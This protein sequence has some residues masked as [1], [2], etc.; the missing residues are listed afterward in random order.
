[1]PID[2]FKQQDTYLCIAFNSSDSIMVTGNETDIKI[3]N[4]NNRRIQL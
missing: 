3:W 2:L 1:M 4:F